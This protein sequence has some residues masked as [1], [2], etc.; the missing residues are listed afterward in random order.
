MDKPELIK[1]ISFSEAHVLRDLVDYQKVKPFK[2]LLAV[3]KKPK[4]ECARLIENGSKDK[5]TSESGKELYIYWKG[6]T[7]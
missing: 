2:M 4:D 6:L 7:H 3:V 5:R 1:N